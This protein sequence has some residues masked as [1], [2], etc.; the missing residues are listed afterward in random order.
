MKLDLGAYPTLDRARAQL[1]ESPDRDRESFDEDL[2]RLVQASAGTCGEG[3]GKSCYYC[4]EPCDGYAGN[5]GKWPVALTHE[6]EPGKV[7]WHH[8]SC[9]S[10]RLRELVAVED[11][12]IASNDDMKQSGMRQF[13]VVRG[14][15]QERDRALHMVDELQKTGTRLVEER[16][17]AVA[18]LESKNAL[19]IAGYGDADLKRRVQYAPIREQVLEFH[20]A[21]DVPVLEKPA[22]PADER[23]RL[24][25]R[26]VAEEF[27]ELVRSIF[28]DRAY[29][30]LP[31]SEMHDKIDNFIRDV[32]IK[33]DLPELADALADLDYVIEGARLEFGFDGA[34]VAAG[35][36]AANMRKLDGPVREDGK[37]LKPEGWKPCDVAA[38]LRR[39]GWEP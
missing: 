26:L 20:R 33:V 12:L 30:S 8:T 16:R 7:K 2:R 24:R 35:V 28:E 36:H 4:E 38:E 22:V 29:L 27:I 19:L 17:A 23:V 10:E 37:R 31:L 32:P 18:S 34:P 6:D 39:Q 25:L 15:I 9:V 3:H 21:M 11:A 1:V 14:V 13:E 5:P